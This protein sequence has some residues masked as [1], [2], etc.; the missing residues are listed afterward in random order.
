M[1]WASPYFPSP[2]HEVTPARP[3]RHQRTKIQENLGMKRI[4]THRIVTGSKPV[5]HISASAILFALLLSAAWAFGSSAEAQE[6]A[7]LQTWVRKIYATD[8]FEVRV[9]VV[10]R[11]REP[12]QAY[13][14]VDPS[15]AQK[16]ALDIVRYETA[17]GM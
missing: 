4:T 13:T 17:T 5:R 12:G 8:D 14:T 11:G 16:G 15:A 10:G 3:R 2:E 9:F 6:K 7:D 1:C